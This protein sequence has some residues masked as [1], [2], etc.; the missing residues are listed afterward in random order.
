MKERTSMYFYTN[1]FN[2]AAFSENRQNYIKFSMSCEIFE[3]RDLSLEDERQSQWVIHYYIENPP[4][5]I[6]N[7]VDES[8]ED[9]SGMMFINDTDLNEQ[10]F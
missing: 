8:L 2:D 10:Y 3:W 9:I 7:N 5:K 6:E 1:P 4:E